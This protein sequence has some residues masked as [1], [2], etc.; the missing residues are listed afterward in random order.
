MSECELVNSIGL[1]FRL[2][3]RCSVDDISDLKFLP[4]QRELLRQCFAKEREAV[5]MVCLVIS[6]GKMPLLKNFCSNLLKYAFE[7][8]LIC[9]SLLTSEG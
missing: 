9:L 6:M 1:Y 3:C 8:N 7:S 5:L 4:T 2:V